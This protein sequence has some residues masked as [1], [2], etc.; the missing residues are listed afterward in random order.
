VGGR[1]LLA[2]ELDRCGA[3]LLFTN[4]PLE[5]TP[6]SWLFFQRRGTLAECERAKFLERTQRGRLDRTKACDVLGGE[7]PD[8]YPPIAETHQGCWQES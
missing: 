2:E 8:G 7:V 5:S 4:Q 1:L 3:R 6:E